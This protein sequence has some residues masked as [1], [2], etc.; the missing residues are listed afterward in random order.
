MGADGWG[1]RLGLKH[2]KEGVWREKT[3]E[4]RSDMSYF[5]KCMYRENIYRNYSKLFHLERTCR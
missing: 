4:G 5:I 2:D 3:K 1:N